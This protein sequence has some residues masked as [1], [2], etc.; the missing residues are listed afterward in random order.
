MLEKI[1]SLADRL[2]TVLE[3]RQDLRERYGEE[4]LKKV[5]KGVNLSEEEK[6]WHEANQSARAQHDMD[7]TVE[8]VTGQDAGP[9]TP[10]REALASA[11]K[12]VAD[13]VLKGMEAEEEIKKQEGR[14]RQAIKRELQKFHLRGVLPDYANNN[15]FSLPRLEQM[16]EDVVEVGK[17]Y[18]D[19][20]KGLDKPVEKKTETTF[21][22]AASAIPPLKAPE[23]LAEKI[24][25]DDIN[26]LGAKFVEMKGMA[27][28]TKLVQETCSNFITKG[29]KV[30][31]QT[32][33]PG[34]N[35]I[36]PRQ[37]GILRVAIFN[38]VGLPPEKADNDFLS[39]PP[40]EAF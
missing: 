14:L 34:Q 9:L 40:D 16:Y 4:K 33:I 35:S 2:V 7:P 23:K 26:I 37:F 1:L 24:T 25:L 11:K 13:G 30:I 39:L 28:W 8:S 12:A 38:A 20:K 36:D 17:V 21:P 5:H 22:E 31:T 15:R 10:Y 27:E 6:I 19:G 3:R 18:E 29:S 32:Y